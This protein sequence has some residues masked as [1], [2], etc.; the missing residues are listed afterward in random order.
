[1][2]LKRRNRE[3]MMS[4]CL[5]WFPISGLEEPNI[6]QNL[7]WIT[8]CGDIYDSVVFFDFEVFWGV[9]VLEGGY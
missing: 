1:M 3:R 8:I 6:Y 5:T 2:E 4:I 9:F 7:V